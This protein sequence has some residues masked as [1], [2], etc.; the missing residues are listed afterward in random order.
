MDQSTKLRAAIAVLTL[1]YAALVPAQDRST[2]RTGR[3]YVGGA[4]GLGGYDAD[5]ERTKAI[6]RSTGATTF[7]VSANGTDTMGKA[8]VGYS[9]SRYV[10]LEGGYWNFGRVS[11]STSISAPAATSMQR[12]ISGDGYGAD[13][14]LWMP[15]ND[16]FSGMVRA[17]AI[18]TTVK[19]TASD[20]GAGL[21]AL[22]AESSQKVDAHWG[23]GVEYR[24]A[25]SAAARFEFETVRKVGD[26]AKF[27]TAD[28]KLWT[29][30]ANY[31]F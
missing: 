22:P 31:R 17:G 3:W 26:N 6:V 12:H 7:N 10:S 4:I 23:L 27:G 9:F 11:I 24:L 21:S 30:G 19:A 15:V 14:V 25:P 18:W 1:L 29:I 2:D 13:A 28:V 20:P 5:F 16:I 8:Y